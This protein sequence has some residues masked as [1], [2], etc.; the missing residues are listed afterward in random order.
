MRI[1]ALII[2]SFDAFI[3][4]CLSKVTTG[5]LHGTTKEALP[6]EY[7][8]AVLIMLSVTVATYYWAVLA[9]T[10]GLAWLCHPF[11]VTSSYLSSCALLTL[12][13]KHVPTGSS[14]QRAPTSS[15][16]RRRTSRQASV[17]L[18]LLNCAFADV[19]LEL[20]VRRHGW[21]VSCRGDIPNVYRSPT[22]AHEHGFLTISEAIVI[23][24]ATELTQT[25]K[26]RS[27]RWAGCIFLQHSCCSC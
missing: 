6:C 14:F 27:G 13:Q 17:A 10:F 26:F 3:V 4:V 12:W 18:S 22:D 2:H 20:T 19:V 7:E 16:G 1:L 11:T 25:S 15:T 5:E 24:R 23:Y 8:R 9:L 21:L